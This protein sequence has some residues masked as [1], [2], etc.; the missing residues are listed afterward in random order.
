[1]LYE[2]ASSIEGQENAQKFLLLEAEALETEN[3]LGLEKEKASV[4]INIKPLAEMLKCDGFVR[5]L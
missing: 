3:A 5:Q 1:M 2:Y 4:D